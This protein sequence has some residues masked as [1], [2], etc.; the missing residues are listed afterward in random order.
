MAN[1]NDGPFRH[2]DIYFAPQAT[3]DLAQGATRA[4]HPDGSLKPGAPEPNRVTPGPL[5]GDILWMFDLSSGAGIWSHDAAHSSILIRGDHLYL[6]TGTGV[7]NTT[8]ASGGPTR[9]ACRAR[10]ALR[11]LPRPRSRGHRGQHLPLQLGAPVLARVGERDLVFFARGNGLSTPSTPAD[12]ASPGEVATLA[13][14][15]EV[16]FRPSGRNPTFTATT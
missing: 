12:D 15:L 16:R 2:E 8:S 4:F 3:N 9:R 1:G 13:R 7:D 10:Q 11:P 5:D 6:N 14:R